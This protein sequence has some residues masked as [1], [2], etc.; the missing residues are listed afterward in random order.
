MIHKKTLFKSIRYSCFRWVHFKFLHNS[1]FDLTAKSLVTNSVVIM[2]VLCTQDNLKIIF[3]ISQ[4]KHVVTTRQD[5]SNG[6]SQNMFYR[7][8]W[9]IIPDTPSYRSTNDIRVLLKLLTSLPLTKAPSCRH[10][11][12]Y[13]FHGQGPEI[14]LKGLYNC[15]H[16]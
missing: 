16:S 2:R 13:L 12:A 1:I 10:T 5:G 15:I 11:I 7:E 8:M 9:L 6:R 4:R 3:L 14:L